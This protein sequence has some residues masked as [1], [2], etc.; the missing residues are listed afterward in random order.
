M[1][2]M[3]LEHHISFGKITI[4]RLDFRDYATAGDYLA[5]D[6]QGAVATRHTLIASMTGQDRVVIERLHGMDYLRAEKMADDLIG[7]CEK[8]YQEFLESG[9]QKKKWPESS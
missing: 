5:F 1:N 3:N 6:T 4:D 7:E 2:T 8:Q 9:N